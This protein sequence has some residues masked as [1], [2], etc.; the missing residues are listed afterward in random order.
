[1]V[2]LDIWDACFPQPEFDFITKKLTIWQCWGVLI[3]RIRAEI[4]MNLAPTCGSGTK[5][6]TAY[7][8]GFS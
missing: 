6:P 8:V 3:H 1:M 5:K 4:S 2:L 7:A